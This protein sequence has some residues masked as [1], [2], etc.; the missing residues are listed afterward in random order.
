MYTDPLA[1]LRSALLIGCVHAALAVS[2]AAADAPPVDA[3]PAGGSTV[4]SEPGPASVARMGAAQ[5]ILASRLGEIVLVDV[6]SP[7]QRALGHIQGDIGIPLDQLAMRRAQLPPNQRIVFYCS[8]RAEELA[9]DAAGVLLRAGRPNVAVLVGGYDA[10]RAAGGPTEID[11]TWEETF[12]VMAPPSGWGKTPI[13]STRCGYFKDGQVAA[14]GSA[15]GHI[16]CRADSAAR[17]FAGFTQKIDAKNLQGR[18]VTLSALVRSQG[19]GRAAFLLIAVEDTTGRVITVYRG[20]KDP[21]TGTQD[22]RSAEVSGAIPPA[23]VKLLIGIS[24]VGSGQVWLDDVRLTAPEEPGRPALS[25]AVVNPGF[26][27]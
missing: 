19:V 11:A 18:A 13:D 2:P 20:E 7:A 5:A 27:D 9:L 17:G 23:A 15:S 22:W 24:L 8:C 4:S 14:K 12:R 1:M 3:P 21:I 16:A 6:R 10:W 25:I 26:E